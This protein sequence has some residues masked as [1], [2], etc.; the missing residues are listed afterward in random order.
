MGYVKLKGA[1]TSESDKTAQ[2]EAEK[3]EMPD[4]RL[5]KAR[6]LFDG[7]YYQRAYDLLKNQASAYSNDRRKN[8]EY[9]YRLGRIAH[10][11]N[12]TQDA[13]RLYT[14]AI[15]NGSKD[16][17]YFACNA[18]LQLGLLYEEKKDASNAR[19]AFNRCLGM[20]PEEYTA[21]L[22]AQA[23]AGLGRLK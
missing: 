3:N 12:K 5:L 8:L 7:G 18:A 6:L 1:A 9:S 10:K 17:W 4:Q 16:P 11:L 13:I 15:D 22:H 2:R 23:K 19:T 14:Y 20:K 21:S